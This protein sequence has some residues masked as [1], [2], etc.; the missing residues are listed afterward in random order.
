MKWIP[1][2]GYHQKP[3]PNECV[4]LSDGKDIFYDMV[5]LDEFMYDGKKIK[6]GW[7]W[8]SGVEPLNINPTHWIVLELP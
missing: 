3:K 2:D 8:V 1:I 4:I 6:S 7:Y 5:W